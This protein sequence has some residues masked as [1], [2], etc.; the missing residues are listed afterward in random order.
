MLRLGSL[1]VCALVVVATSAAPLLAEGD[2]MATVT[3]RVVQMMLPTNETEARVSG[4]ML[5]N[6]A[7]H[8]HRTFTVTILHVTPCIT[9]IANLHR[10]FALLTLKTCTTPTIFVNHQ[11]T[12]LSHRRHAT[13]LPVH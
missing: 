9:A 10:C 5:C 11:L 7:E 1:I 6:H 2:D 13:T 12:P 8:Q 3:R 4:A